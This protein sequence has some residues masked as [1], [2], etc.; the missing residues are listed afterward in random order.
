MDEV[1]VA[2]A[3]V[4]WAVASALLVGPRVVGMGSEHR[5]PCSNYSP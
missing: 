5:T 1:S 3:G 2:L 4:H